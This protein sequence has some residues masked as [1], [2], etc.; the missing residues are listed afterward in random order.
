MIQ[1]EKVTMRFDDK[2]A[3]LGLSC[4]IPDGCIYGLVGSNGAGKSTFLRLIS[5]IY[6]PHGGKITFDGLPV[7][8]N[9]EVK[10]K[11]VFVSDDLY[12]LPQA[13]MNRMA[14]MYRSIYDTFSMEFLFEHKKGSHH[15]Q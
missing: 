5:G 13:S 12:F 3:L 7:Y 15:E 2:T 6:K 9:P 8:E 11:L 14:A 1:A 4:Q 10:S